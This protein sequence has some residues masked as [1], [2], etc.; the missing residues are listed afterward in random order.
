MAPKKLKKKIGAAPT[1]ASELL[2]AGVDEEDHGDRW[3]SSGDPAKAIRFYQRACKFYAQ[4]V[5][6][7]GSQSSISLDCLYNV[8]R[9]QFLVY[10]K[11]IKTGV[12]PDIAKDLNEDS[13]TFPAVV[14]DL[15]TIE[16]THEAAIDLSLHINGSSALD[17]LH[18]YAQVLV[19][20]G[21]EFNSIDKFSKAFQLMDDIVKRENQEFLNMLSTEVDEDEDIDLEKKSKDLMVAANTNRAAVMQNQVSESDN[22][23]MITPTNLLETVISYIQGITTFYSLIIDGSLP[24]S[25]DIETIYARGVDLLDKAH[26]L[27]SEFGTSAATNKVVSDNNI[28]REP[29]E[30]A[31]LAVA[32]YNSSTTILKALVTNQLS[33]ISVVTL[34]SIWDQT[35]LD[36]KSRFMAQS[37]ALMELAGALS[38]FDDT[39]MQTLSWDAYTATSKLVTESLSRCKGIQTQAVSAQ[40]KLYKAK[41]DI[42]YLRSCLKIPAAVKNNAILLQNA[43]TFY[44]NV[45]KL[46]SLGISLEDQLIVQEATR[47]KEALELSQFDMWQFA[48]D[49]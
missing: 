43:I 1:T 48:H 38:K 24:V 39:K 10:S 13:D 17:L 2:D 46:S 12:L 40:R 6:Y 18:N 45:I 21:E 28:E 23:D 44:S 31:L 35:N 41:G 26:S 36:S 25:D 33:S 27:I 11:V 47:K 9:I 8:A 3:I 15:N 30:E 14:S 16:K 20:A 7:D 19:E 34:N 32:Q 29:I 42:E 22:K 37:D 4:A 5:Q 49:S